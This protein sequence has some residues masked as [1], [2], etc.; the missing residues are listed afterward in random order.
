MSIFFF[1]ASAP[2]DFVVEKFQDLQNDKEYSIPSDRL[3][4][5]SL[6]GPNINKS[7]WKLLNDI[8]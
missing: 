4:N 5:I 2:A 7:I 8:N 6:D 1:F 3:F